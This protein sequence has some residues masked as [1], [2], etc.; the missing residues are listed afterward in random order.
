MIT[1]HHALNLLLTTLV[2]GVNQINCLQFRMRLVINPGEYFCLHQFLAPN[3]Y[4]HNDVLV[5]SPNKLDIS[6]KIY[7]AKKEVIKHEKEIGFWAKFHTNYE[8]SG[9]YRFCFDNTYSLINEKL[10]FF[11]LTTN[12]EYQDPE[13]LNLEKYKYLAETDKLGGELDSK[14]G[15]FKRTLDKMLVQFGEV[16]R[17]QDMY[18]EH[19][20]ISRIVAEMTYAFV[21]IW[22]MLS[23]S[24]M[25]VSSISQVFF[26]KC[27]FD[28]NSRV[29]RFLRSGH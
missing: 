7:S 22:S 24:M 6:Y 4:L 12:N 2:F 5:I 11:G 3:L 16:Q 21:N 26:F 19:E 8:G 1:K 15:E 10:V 17:I 28:N 18:K 9:E 14:I 25:V 20:R 23:I 13:F 29:G 27:L